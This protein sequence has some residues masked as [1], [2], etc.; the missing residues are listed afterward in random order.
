VGD[1]GV[2]DATYKAMK[3]YR[4]YDGNRSGFGDTSV[5]ASTPNP[6]AVSAFAALRSSD[7]ALTIMVI[8]KVLTGTTATTVNLSN[9]VPGSSAQVW[10]LTS[11]NNIMRLADI[12]IGGSSFSVSVPAQS[13]TLLVIPTAGGGALPV[14]PKNLRIVG[15]ATTP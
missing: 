1:A 14:T 4:N 9:F 13:I 3:M 6:D 15:T 11:A 5:A 7:R 2:D 12:T 8:A 10:Q